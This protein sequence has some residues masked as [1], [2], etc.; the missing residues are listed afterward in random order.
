MHSSQYNVHLTTFPTATTSL[1][2]TT[3][4]KWGSKIAIQKKK[5]QVWIK[6]PLWERHSGSYILEPHRS[7]RA[8][9]AGKTCTFIIH[10]HRH[11][12][13]CACTREVI[14]FFSS[15]VT[16]RS[17]Y[18]QLGCWPVLLHFFSTLYRAYTKEIDHG[19]SRSFT[20]A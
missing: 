5:Y 3:V 13:K 10:T 19:F 14:I 2:A 9:S 8:W 18:V 11:N 1:Y 16:I 7:A 17:V 12:Y 15:Y 6:R 4:A 20:D